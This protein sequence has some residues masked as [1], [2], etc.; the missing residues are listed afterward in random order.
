[1][2]LSKTFDRLGNMLLGSSLIKQFNKLIGS[3][4]SLNDYP[5]NK[6]VLHLLISLLVEK[7]QSLRICYIQN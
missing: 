1:M 4:L 3:Y 6:Q 7:H 5:F 2:Y